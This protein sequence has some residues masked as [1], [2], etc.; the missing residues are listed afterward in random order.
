M[1]NTARIIPG[2]SVAIVGLGGVGLSALLAAIM[3]GAGQVIAID[4]NDEKLELAKQL[5]AHLVFNAKS[6]SSVDEIR[7]ATSGGTHIAVETAGAASALDLAYKITR[8]GGSTIAAGMPGPNASIN[9]SHLSL[10]AEERTLKGSYM[11]SCVPG[12][13]IPRYLS[14]FQDGKLPIDRLT[15]HQIGLEDLNEAFDR[16]EEGL[17]IRQVLVF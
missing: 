13:D 10:A 5:G 8:R 3:S 11:G 17:A 7:A 6:T 1:V 9:L 15:S 16:M 2:Q 14:L 12:R 4:V